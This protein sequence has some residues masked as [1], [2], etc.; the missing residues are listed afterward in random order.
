[1]ASTVA[2]YLAGI[3]DSVDSEFEIVVQLLQNGHFAIANAVAVVAEH[4]IVESLG[5]E[6]FHDLC[7]IPMN[8]IWNK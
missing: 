2:A 7:D 8:I 4:I 3:D 1:M 5:L 6:D